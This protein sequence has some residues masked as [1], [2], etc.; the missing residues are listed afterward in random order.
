MSD[1]LLRLGVPFAVYTL[2]VWPLLEYALFGPLLRGWDSITDTDPVLDNGPMWFVGVLLL[3]SVALAAWRR[4]VPPSRRRTEPLRWR[5]LVAL[6]LAV[7][8]ASFGLR[9]VLPIDSNQ[10]LNLH[11]VGLAGVHRDVLPR[12]HRGCLRPV[13]PALARRCGIATLAATLAIAIV[14]VSTDV[15]GLRA[16]GVLRGGDCWRWCGRWPRACSLSGTDLG[17]WRSPRGA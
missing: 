1:R 6:A 12:H 5:H 14:A 16:G 3:F 10:P 4:R 7:G 8:V 2:V 9:I 15:R 11:L 17:C 13:P